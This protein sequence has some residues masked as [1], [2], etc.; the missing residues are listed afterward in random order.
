MESQIEYSVISQIKQFIV[1]VFQTIVS[2]GSSYMPMPEKYTNA[3][4]GRIN[5][6]KYYETCFYWCMKYH[7]SGKEHNCDLLTV[8]AKLEDEHNYDHVQ[9]LASYDDIKT[10]EENNKVG[11]IVYEMGENAIAT[12]YY[13]NNC[14]LLNDRV[15]LSKM[16]MKRDRS[17]FILNIVK[18]CFIKTL[19]FR[20][21]TKSC[22]PIART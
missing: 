18:H 10:F 9:F 13:G 8:L 2:R 14:Y 7:S 22:V 15:Y 4:C 20:V 3:R 11:V 1:R 16:K 5:I 19:T 17:I 21:L 6:N 12:Q